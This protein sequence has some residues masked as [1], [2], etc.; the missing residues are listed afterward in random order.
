MRAS[1]R[2]GRSCVSVRERE[3]FP[4]AG[5]QNGEMCSG[6]GS[7]THLFLFVFA[8]MCKDFEE[9]VQIFLLCAKVFKNCGGIC[10]YR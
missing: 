5:G 9:K 6:S 2:A 10:G 1:E 7:G 4:N 8:S 3:V